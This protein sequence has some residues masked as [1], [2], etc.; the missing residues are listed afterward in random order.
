MES[1]GTLKIHQVNLSTGTCFGSNLT[2]ESL[3]C[4]NH[5][6]KAA[7]CSVTLGKVTGDVSDVCRANFS[8]S[9]SLWRGVTF[10]SI[11]SH[12]SPP[13]VDSTREIQLVYWKGSLFNRDCSSICS[14][15]GHLRWFLC[16]SRRTAGWI[17]TGSPHKYLWCS[18][19]FTTSKQEAHKVGCVCY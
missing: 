15:G 2:P 12:A 7:V 16:I 8:L 17:L 4:H 6:T 19:I 10:L 9:D 5:T 3:S 13:T 14:S 11:Q 18:D 1:P